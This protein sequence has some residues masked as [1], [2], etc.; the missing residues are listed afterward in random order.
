LILNNTGRELLPAAY[1]ADLGVNLKPLP[2]LL[3][4]AAA[5]YLYLEQEFVYVGDEGVVEASGKTRRIGI[6]LS[7][8]YQVVKWL[9]ADINLNIAKPRS[10][11]ESKG[12][13]FIPLAPTFTSTG[14]L[15]WQLGNGINGSLRYRHLSDRPANENNSVLAK[16]YSIADLSINYS[17]K[18]YELGLAI[19]NLFNTKWNETQFE[20]ESRLRNETDPVTE[21]HFTPGVPF[22]AKLKMAIFF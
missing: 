12:E 5:W 18:K 1:G 6:D 9:F 15:S 11:Q 20:T 2:G 13:D 8:R 22:F 7:A 17:R 19:E 16:G 4:N 14:G 21:I 3:L 10:I